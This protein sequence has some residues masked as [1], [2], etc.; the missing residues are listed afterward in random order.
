MTIHMRDA[1]RM[2]DL[3]NLVR[4]E[5]YKLKRRKVFG[6]VRSSDSGDDDIGSCAGICL[7]CIAS[8]AAWIGVVGA[9]MVYSQAKNGW[10]VSVTG[11]VVFV[12]ALVRLAK[13]GRHE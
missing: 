7:I 9:F 12:L 11:L 4:L 2:L 8:M 5:Q 3:A 1:K 10:L 6:Q 13:V